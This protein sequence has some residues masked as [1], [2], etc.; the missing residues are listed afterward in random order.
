M[1]LEI[2]YYAKDPDLRHITY[3]I[4]KF[5][6]KVSNIEYKIRRLDAIPTDFYNKNRKQYRGDYVNIWLRNL[7]DSDLVSGILDVDG[8]VPGLNFI[9]GVATPAINTFTVYL[10][11]LKYDAN[12]DLFYL[13]V[14]KEFMHELGHVLG[15]EHC[16]IK[17][18]VMSFSNTIHEV[19]YKEAKFCPLHFN[20]L[21]KLG[22][23]LDPSLEL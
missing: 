23:T 14:Q 1:E 19:D 10:H 12:E 8:Y 18:C 9:F 6:W 11:R 13:R 16:G 5:L 4:T 17:K 20:K 21:L 22:F 15:L 7:S 2:L 3:P